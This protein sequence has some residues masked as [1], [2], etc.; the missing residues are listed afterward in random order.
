L[1]PHPEISLFG[2]KVQNASCGQW[3]VTDVSPAVDCH[4][5]GAVDRKDIQL[6]AMG[7]SLTA[8]VPLSAWVTARGRG[9]LGKNVQVTAN[10]DMMLTGRIT[11][12]V[13]PDWQPQLTLDPSYT[14][15]TPPNFHILGIDVTIADKV[16]PPLRNAM[17]QF[18]GV[19]LQ[20]VQ[21]LKLRA[22]AEQLWKKAFEPLAVSHSPDVWVRFT[23]QQVGLS[24]VSS[25]EQSLNLNLMASGVTETFVGP[26]PT[27]SPVTTLPPLRKDLPSAA[28]AFYLP[29]YADYSA[30]AET[31][32]KLLRVG[33]SQEFSVPSIGLTRV[34]FTDVTL[35]PTTGNAIAIGISMQAKP[36]Q[37]WFA[38]TGT[39]WITGKIKID[40]ATEKLEPEELDFGAATD[41]TAAN[42]LASIARAAPIRSKIEASLT[43]D[44]S[45]EYTNA[46]QRAN[47]ALN[48]SLP[49]NIALS[50]AI[51]QANVDQITAT[52]HGVY[53]GMHILGN[54]RIEA[55]APDQL[56]KN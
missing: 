3:V 43:Y 30:A 34:T 14:W 12:D 45:K 32:K 23:P 38:A 33:E 24:G 40:S 52:A 56:T 26:K 48:Q 49:D 39:A 41:N 2:H 19:L 16:D 27:P 9:E 35:Y 51:T 25:D 37:R 44:F 31:L 28:F 55:L 1:L 18:K 7:N 6:S 11:A 10:G 13:T 21:D 5:T 4:L 22:S 46:L 8:S 53:M 50:G 15:T 20:R 17:E 47:A 36:P 42:L 29:I 54:V